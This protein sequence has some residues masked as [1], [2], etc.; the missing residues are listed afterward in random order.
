MIIETLP[1]LPLG[2]FALLALCALLSLAACGPGAGETAS[3][4]AGSPGGGQGTSSGTRLDPQPSFY[5]GGIQVNEA[6]HAI[7][8]ENLK[9]QGMNTVQVTEY[10]MQGDWDT[11]HMWWDEEAPWVIEEI[12]GAKRHGIAVVL[13]LRVALDHAFERNAFLW[14]GMIAPKTEAML[15]SWFEQYGRFCRKWAEIAEREGVDLLMVGSEMN[16]LAS[17]LPLGELPPLEEY[18]LNQEKQERRRQ[19]TLA[20]RRMLEGRELHLPDEESFETVEGYLDA[21][22]TKEQTWALQT[23][24]LDPGALRVTEEGQLEPESARLALD[25]LNGRRQRLQGH[26]EALIRGIRAVYSGSLGY[27]ANFD[28]YHEVGFWPL[29]DVMGI[30]AYFKLRNEMV[31]AGD[32]ERLRGLLV[33]GWRE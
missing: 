10:A 21:R 2:R 15:A 3:S 32:T 7:W 16:A 13:V 22:I 6:D 12:R 20:Q 8:F 19:E 23:L 25:S 30:N 31:E 28:Q 17:T 4:A 27:A 33:D 5:L 9:S 26:W 14:H 29:L 1:A 24:G 11:D 18:F